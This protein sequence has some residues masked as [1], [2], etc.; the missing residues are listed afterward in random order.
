M[1]KISENLQK[2]RKEHPGASVRFQTDSLELPKSQMALDRTGR[3]RVK[4]TAVVDCATEVLRL[5]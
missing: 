2:N 3:S 1:L 5:L 4:I